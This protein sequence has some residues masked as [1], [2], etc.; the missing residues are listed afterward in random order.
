MTREF[1]LQVEAYQLLQLHIALGGV[2]ATSQNKKLLQGVPSGHIE[3]VYA[4]AHNLPE[5]IQQ[6]AAAG[7]KCGNVDLG[8]MHIFDPNHSATNELITNLMTKPGSFKWWG[9]DRAGKMYPCVV[10]TKEQP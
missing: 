7:V 2:M 4:D 6:H 5:A 1:H 9:K 10:V 8:D 3:F